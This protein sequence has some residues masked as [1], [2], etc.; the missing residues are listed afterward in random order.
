[1]GERNAFPRRKIRKGDDV[2]P[3][4]SRVEE[5]YSALCDLQQRNIAFLH[6][7]LSRVLDEVQK[8]R[9]EREAEAERLSF[10]V[11]ELEAERERDKALVPLDDF[12]PRCARPWR[13]WD[14]STYR[15]FQCGED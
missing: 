2:Q 12:C 11:A 7:V 3:Q 13:Y 9:G 15:C 4:R 10:R 8:E 1:M 5:F 6:R 14:G